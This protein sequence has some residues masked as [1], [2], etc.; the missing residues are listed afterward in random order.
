MK[1]AKATQ[2]EKQNETIER[3]EA[4]RYVGIKTV[5]A[6]P[7]TRKAYNDLRGW[8]LPADE[9]GEDAG[10]LVE[11][12]DGGKANCAGFD[13]YVSWSP[14]DVF[15]RAYTPDT[16]LRFGDAVKLMEKGVKVGRISWPD[17]F[18]YL[19]NNP[20]C[21]DTLNIRMSDGS[22]GSW[23]PAKDDILA[24]DWCVLELLDD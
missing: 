20:A 17:N 9:N 7:M 13:G 21:A 22:D 3:P 4:K 19:W 12:E 16:G 8:E 1:N 24:D 15:E 11:Y 14:A 5:K 10:F 2:D 6:F 18:S 23:W